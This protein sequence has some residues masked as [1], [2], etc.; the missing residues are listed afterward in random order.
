MTKLQWLRAVWKSQSTLEAWNNYLKY[1]NH[2]NKIIKETKRSHFRSQMHELSNKLKSVW[3]FAK[4][5]RIESQLLKKLSQFLSLKSND[6]DHIADSFKEKTEMLWKKFF[7][8]LSQA[9]INNIS[10]SFILLTMSFNSVLLQDEMRQTIQR[11]KV[12]KASDTFEIS[13]R[14]FQA[15]LTELTSILINLFNACITHKYHLKQFKKAQTIVLC[16]SKKSDYIDLKMY[17]LIA[18]LNIMN[19]TLKS[20]MIKRLSDITETH[21]MLLNAQMRAR[22]KQF[23][24][25]ALNL[26]V[27]QVHAVWDCEIKYVIFMLS[28]DVA[29]MFNHV[30]HTRLLHTLRMRR[31]SNYIVEWTRSFLKNR[32]SLLTFNEQI[33][34]MRRV[35]ANISQKSLI[36]S[37]LFLFFN[38]SLI[39][40]CE[41]LEIKIKV[42][43]FVNDI[44][45]L[46][47]DKITES[48]CES[49]SQ[50]HDVCAKWAWTHDTT[51]ASEKYELTHFIHKS[52]RFD[53][54]V[55]LCI[56]NSIIKSKLNVQVLKVQLNTKL[57]WDSHL[58]QI[59]ADHII[60]MLML[61]Q[62][63]IFIWEATFAKARQIYSAMIRS[64][65]MFEAS[66]WHQRNKEERLLNMKQ[67]LETLQNQALRHVIDVF[68]KV[69]IK[70]L[71]VETYTF[72]LHVHLNKLQNQVTL[73]S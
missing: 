44:N 73:R 42:L 54:I 32:E 72:S 36:S 8:S 47:Y 56:E 5:V 50:A 26:L 55:S 60:R 70:T 68:K 12:D 46:I 66:I 17:W 18:L 4:W 58:R 30:S 14:V 11:V 34:A 38:A 10:R 41:A 22:C 49:L 1:N 23:M 59:K 29:E 20:I 63:E 67:R 33:S 21:H 2:K 13:N 35:N 69:N 57:R 45:I 39:K 16:K 31:T 19:K 15:D 25:S 64:R 7:S 43:D 71:K 52:K 6:F 51:F 27:D 65:M 9:N 24:I 53:M 28:L 61:S 48:I 40:K 3:H 37:I 62:L